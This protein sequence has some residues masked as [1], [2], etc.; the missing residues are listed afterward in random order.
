MSLY[1]LLTELF[2]AITAVATFSF[3]TSQSLPKTWG[4]PADGDSL[5]FSNLLSRGELSP[6]LLNTGMPTSSEVETNAAAIQNRT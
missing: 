3:Y 6:H 2:V 4:F 1:A 5:L